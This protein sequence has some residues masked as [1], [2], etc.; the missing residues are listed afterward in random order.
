[1]WMEVADGSVA[2]PFPEHPGHQHQV[3][4]VDPDQVSDSIFSHDRVGK[5]AIDGFI[6]REVLNLQRKLSNEVVKHR[7]EDAVAE[8]F[9]IAFDLVGI[10]RDGP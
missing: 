10:Q 7:P 9:V 6:E 5:A 3:V 8:L 1:M 4:V 2:K